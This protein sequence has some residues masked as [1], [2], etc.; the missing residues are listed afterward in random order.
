VV[1]EISRLGRSP[2]EV[3]KIIEEMNS[4]GISI[5]IQ[6]MNLQTID[7][8]GN[9]SPIVSVLV[10]ILAEFARLER[11]TLITRIKSGLEK[12]RKNGVKLGRKKG[13]VISNDMLLKKY[14]G[15]VKDLEHSIS[16]RKIA[17]IH[18]VSLC[19]ILK[20]KKAMGV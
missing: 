18:S 4:L 5:H 10:S 20:V 11:E 15:V 7:S 19:T 16:M 12:A 8:N 14:R 17:R 2:L 6:T 3:H 1:S 13:S 9:R